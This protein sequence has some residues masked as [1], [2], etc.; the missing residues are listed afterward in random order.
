MDQPCGTGLI[1]LD[2][3][4]LMR[5]RLILVDITSQYELQSGYEN[6]HSTVHI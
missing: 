2:K 3:N 6:I 5:V 4:F 1:L